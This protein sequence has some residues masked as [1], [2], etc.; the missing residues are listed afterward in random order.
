[1]ERKYSLMAYHGQLME[2]S[3]S[4]SSAA[5]AAPLTSLPSILS[6]C[7]FPTHYPHRYERKYSLMAH[8]GQLMEP[9]PSDSTAAAPAVVGAAAG[10]SAAMSYSDRVD[11][12]GGEVV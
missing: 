2:P 8:H 10:S 11:G 6:P 7:Y 9:S 3:P 5:A 12:G 1:Y 4:D